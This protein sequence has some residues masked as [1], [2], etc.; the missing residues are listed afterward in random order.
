MVAELDVKA[1][2]EEMT[3]K[4]D[5]L[6]DRVMKA[7]N[8]DSQWDKMNENLSKINDEIEL[9]HKKIGEVND[10]KDDFGDKLAKRL[11]DMDTKADFQRN[12]TQKAIQIVIDGAQAKFKEIAQD[13][14]ETAQSLEQTVQDAQIKFQEGDEKYDDLYKKAEASYHELNFKI[15][16]G[17]GGKDKKSGFL[18]DKM[19]VPHKFS[20]DITMWRKWKEETT[21]YFDEG[22][23]GIKGIMDEVGKSGRVITAEVLEEAAQNN[24]HKIEGLKKWKHLYRALEK[25]T[26]GEA[27]KVISTVADENGF[28]AWRQLH[29]RFEPELEAQKNTVLVDLHNITAAITINET[30]EKLFELKVRITRAGDILGVP[31]QCGYQKVGSM[32]TKKKMQGPRPKKWKPIKCEKGE[33]ILDEAVIK[34]YLRHQGYGNVNTIRSIEPEGINSV[35]ADG[36]WEQIELAVDSGATESVTPAST[37]THVPTTDNEESRRG[38]RYEVANGDSIP[39]E[40]EKRFKAFTEE[41]TQKQM[42]LQVCDVS[43]SLLSVSKMTKAGNR[44]VFDSDG[45]FI[46][47][48]TSGDIT[49]L[50]ERGGMYIFKLWIRRPF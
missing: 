48:K 37:P 35:T 23:E 13:I 28:E 20:Q 14:T 19:M 6:E 43:Q 27:A 15:N 4:L 7:E 40:G 49:W 29:L 33:K 22:R 24:P 31:I 38:V 9:L 2:M 21:K 34:G 36:Q 44:V 47:N 3:K 17:G 16:M 12:D 26:D 18:P 42:V 25:L 45:S 39:N 1:A 5:G 46:M 41:G 10:I 8:K 11:A 30:K 32:K 50:Q